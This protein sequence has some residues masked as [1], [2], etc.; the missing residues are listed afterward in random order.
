MHR[1]G[2]P[3]KDSLSKRLDRRVRWVHRMQ[4]RAKA[5]V[6]LDLVELLQGS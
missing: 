1:N 5:L 4:L 6:M 2:P 3:D